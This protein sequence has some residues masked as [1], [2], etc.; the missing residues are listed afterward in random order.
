MRKCSRDR[1]VC[2]PPELIGKD[3]N[4]T[5]AILL[6]PRGSHGCSFP[7]DGVVASSAWTSG[8][9]TRCSATNHTC[10]SLVRI[11]LLTRTSLVP[12]ESLGARVPQVVCCELQL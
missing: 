4:R 10:G 11:T 7:T 2:A 12:Y 8:P 5:E 3:V 6:N 9:S 1:C